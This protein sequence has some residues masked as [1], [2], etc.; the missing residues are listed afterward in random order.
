MRESTISLAG[1]SAIVVEPDATPRFSVILLHGYAMTPADLA[2]FAHSMG[3]PLRFIVPQ[4]PLPA[5]PT[6]CAWWP[7]DHESR[8]TALRLGARDLHAEHPAG[9]AAARAQLVALREALTAR[10]GDQPVALVGFS[11]GALLACDTVLRETF[12]VVG[13]ALLSASRISADEWVA[14]LGRLHTLPVLISHG[15]HD[16]D[17]A[18]SAGEALRDLIATSGAQVT[19]VPHPGGHTIPIAVWRA[20]RRFLRALT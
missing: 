7:L 20:L 11:Q 16:A 15:E 1:L 4:G 8:A 6:G 2:P 17:L 12:P 5:T 18:F 14:F 9:A 10:Y 3:L 13:L 19:W